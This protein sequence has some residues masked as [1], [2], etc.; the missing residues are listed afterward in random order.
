[1]KHMILQKFDPG[2]TVIKEGDIGNDFWV[3]LSGKVTVY[4]GRSLNFRPIHKQ[5]NNN[6]INYP[7]T[8]Q[9]IYMKY[10]K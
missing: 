8:P 9:Y 3:I 5:R 10:L 1:M 7:P 2:E 4:K 6:K